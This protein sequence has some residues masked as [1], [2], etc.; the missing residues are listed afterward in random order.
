MALVLALVMAATAIEPFTSG[1][2]AGASTSARP[3]LAIGATVAAAAAGASS[4]AGSPSSSGSLTLNYQSPW[5]TPDQPFDVKLRTGAGA[6]PTSDLGLSVAVYGCLTSVSSFDQAATAASPTGSPIA[7]T[8]SALPW[9]SLHPDA[10]G[11]DVS[12]GVST[13]SSA[14]TTISTPNPT[15]AIHAGGSSCQEGVFPVRLQLENTNSGASL[16]S[17]TTFMVYVAAPATQKLRFAMVVPVSTAIAP[18]PQPS[19]SSL[20]TNP[21][22]S[23]TRPSTA[24][25]T[26]I[27][28]LVAAMS[29]SPNSSVPVTVAASAQTLQDLTT[30]TPAT[31]G[32]RPAAVN[33]L[34]VLSDTP[35]THQFTPTPYAPV[36]ASALVDAGLSSE[37]VAQLGRGSELLTTPDGIVHSTTPPPPGGSAPWI[38][39]DGLDDNTLAE[40]AT[41]GY[42]QIVLP[43][44]DVSSSP[45]NG[46]GAEP[47][48]INS[49]HGSSFLAI[50]S[51]ADLATRMTAHPGDPVLAASQL[52][53]ELAQIYF[54]YPNLSTARAVVAVPPTGATPNPSMISTLLTDLSNNPFVQGVTTADLFQ[55]LSTPA[56][57]HG[58]CKLTTSGSST[59]SGSGSSTTSGLPAG[60]IRNQRTRIAGLASAIE[61]P[62]SFARTLPVQL[63]DLVLASEAET[64]KPSQQSSVL[65]NASAAVNAQLGQFSLSG[66][67]SI[68]LTS[69]NGQ[70]PVSIASSAPYPATGTLTITSDELLFANGTRRVSLPNTTLTKATNNFPIP[71]QARTSGE[72][73]LEI[74]YTSPSGGMVITS[75]VINVRSTATSIVGVVLS[76]GAVAVLAA[77]WTRTTFRRRKR[78]RTD[79]AEPS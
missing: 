19:A 13:A 22:T 17:L 2:T 7:R 65:H 39:N 6:P 63:G 70:I 72:F 24:T 1:A 58:G 55:T 49:A 5:V 78:R 53:G 56:A 21:L 61:P 16:A 74:T 75:G 38:T 62:S 59:S 76:L 52:L 68:T 67:Q 54:E 46:S 3:A 8:T 27:N 73:K 18:A 12:F 36:D 45:V 44:A 43:P 69:R 15:I 30:A 57:C 28:Q 37:L 47:F 64:L 51:N 42:N 41:I 66:D 26:G 48:T 31:S 71:V 60:T 35:A 32:A 34:A 25:L 29:T 40:L 11:V 23:L 14:S 4:A 79:A 77:W 33:A 50:T 20:L 9:S 10:S